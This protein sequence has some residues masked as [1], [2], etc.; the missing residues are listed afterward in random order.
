RL[1]VPVTLA[2]PLDVNAETLRA[3]LRVAFEDRAYAAYVLVAIGPAP[4]REAT[5]PELATLGE[6]PLAVPVVVAV[7]LAT[8]DE[9]RRL[10]PGTAF[11]PGAECWVDA[12]GAGRGALVAATGERGAWADLTPDGRLVL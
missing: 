5:P 9:L 2:T 4:T 1:R 11:V 6:L 8:R 7:A 12:A 3:K 10:L